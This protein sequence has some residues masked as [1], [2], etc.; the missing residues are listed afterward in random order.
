MVRRGEVQA[1]R[2]PK[3]GGAAGAGGRSRAGGPGRASPRTQRKP[4]AGRP[5][6]STVSTAVWSRRLRPGGSRPGP[7]V[8]PVVTEPLT[9]AGPVAVGGESAFTEPLS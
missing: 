4:A 6:A 9:L 8:R 3:A 7:P 2:V 5:A 1:T